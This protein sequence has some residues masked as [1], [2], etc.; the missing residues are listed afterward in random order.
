MM[1]NHKVKKTRSYVVEQLKKIDRD[2]MLTEDPAI[3]GGMKDK[4]RGLPQSA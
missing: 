4:R 1:A 2:M 3:L